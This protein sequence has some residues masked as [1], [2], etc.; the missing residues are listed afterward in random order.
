MTRKLAIAFGLV[1]LFGGG[2]FW[3]RATHPPLT[4]AEQIAANLEDIRQSLENGNIKNAVGYMAEGAKFKGLSR[5]EIQ[6]QFTLGN[7]FGGRT[8]L[9]M[10][11]LNTRTEVNGATASTKGH[12][13]ADVR[14]RYRPESYDGDFSLE[15][16]KRDGQWVITDGQATG[17][18]PN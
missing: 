3:W 17:D 15:W 8:D 14:T 7:A 13:K 1:F 5:S 2:W 11:F 10:N 16:E 12:Y 6:N 9:R 18:I 4:D